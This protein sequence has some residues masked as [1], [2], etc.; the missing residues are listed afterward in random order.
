MKLILV[1]AFRISEVDND[2]PLISTVF[3]NCFAGRIKYQRSGFF[4]IDYN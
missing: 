1:V 2:Q 4:Y 3:H